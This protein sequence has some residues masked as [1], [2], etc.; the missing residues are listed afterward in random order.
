MIACCWL[1]PAAPAVTMV[2]GPV[3]PVTRPPAADCE[4]TL[5]ITASADGAATTVKPPGA[6][7]ASPAVSSAAKP[8]GPAT[9]IRTPCGEGA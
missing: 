2:T 3:T 5:P 8:A 9:A 6:A 1:N 4:R 7:C